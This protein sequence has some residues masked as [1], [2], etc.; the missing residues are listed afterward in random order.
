MV[1]IG[2]QKQGHK[3]EYIA[4]EGGYVPN[5][6]KNRTLNELITYLKIEK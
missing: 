3:A 4:E 5:I 2:F 1:V 6:I